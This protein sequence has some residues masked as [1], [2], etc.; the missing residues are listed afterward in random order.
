MAIPFQRE[1]NLLRALR[2]VSPVVALALS[3]FAQSPQN[4]EETGSVTIKTNVRQVLVPVVVTDKKG[5]YISGLKVSD[6]QV[7]EDGT[8]Q[9]IVAFSEGPGSSLPPVDS[10]GAGAAPVQGGPKTVLEQPTPANSGLPRQT[11]L[12]CMDTLHS[13]FANFARVRDALRKFFAQAASGDS[14]YALIALGRESTVLRDSTRDPAEILAAVQSKAFQKTIQDSEAKNTAVALQ[15]FY[16]LMGSYCGLCGCGGAPL[17]QELPGC[18][19]VRAQVK[20]FVLSFGQRTAG[21]NQTFLHNLKQVVAA[22]ASMPTSRTIVLISDGFNRFPGNELYAIMQAYDPGDRSMEFNPQNTEDVMQSIIRLAVRNDVRFYT[23]DSRALYTLASL[24]GSG[25]D[26]STS[27]GTSEAVDRAHMS[28]AR[29]NTDGLA[30]LARET[31]GLFFENSNDLL[32]GVRKAF[33][34]GRARYVLAYV[35]ANRKA[36]G[37][38]RKIRVDVQGGRFDVHAKPGYWATPN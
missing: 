14:Q 25:W 9:K 3:A 8:P 30:E 18:P 21:L 19:G 34:D 33:E 24:D 17:K 13:S 35:P 5:H 12:I 37:K 6:F 36:D 11:Y 28:V 23:I 7:L 38:Y 10:A 29:G 22:T 32:K 4:P 1:S 27:G 31:G 15:T 20:G 2:R 16:G 26:A